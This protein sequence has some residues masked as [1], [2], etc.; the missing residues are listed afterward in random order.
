MSI[1]ACFERGKFTNLTDHSY[2][3]Y[4]L[5]NN[6]ITHTGNNTPS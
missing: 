6:V 5:V 4:L 3:S 1:R 2:T